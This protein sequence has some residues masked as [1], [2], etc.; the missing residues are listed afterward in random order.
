MKDYI[1]IYVRFV[2][3]AKANGVI[4]CKSFHCE[5]GNIISVK[6][7]CS[8]VDDFPELVLTVDNVERISGILDLEV[9]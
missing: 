1:Q 6:S 7:L 3:P 4:K 2:D 5:L 9:L 8:D